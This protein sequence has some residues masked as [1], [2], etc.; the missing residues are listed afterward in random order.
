MSVPRRRET[1]LP[2]HLRKRGRSG[3]VICKCGK[4]Y[5][6]EYDGLC[7]YCRGVTAYDAKQARHTP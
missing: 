6:S 7:L 1:P 3:H 5:G 4:G 2:E